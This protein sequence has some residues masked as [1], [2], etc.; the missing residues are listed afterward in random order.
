M[1]A[2][3][4]TAKELTEKQYLM[5]YKLELYILGYTKA[6][7]FTKI[8]NLINFKETTKTNYQE[9]TEIH[10]QNYIEYLHKKQLHSNTIQHYYHSIQQFFV[11]LER[12]QYL[13]KNPCNFYR[14]QLVKQPKT[15]REILSQEEVKEVYK[16]ARKGAETMLLHLCYGCGLRAK[17][18]ERIN[19]EDILLS[20]HIIKVEKGKN[21]QYRVLPIPISM[22]EDIT[23]YLKYNTNKTTLQKALLLN[24]QGNRLKAY[25][26]RKILKSILQRTSITKK[27]TLHSLRHSI[28]T[29]LLANGMK[30]EYVQQFLGHRQLETTEIYTHINKEQ[31]KDLR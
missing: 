15:I 2:F 3:G 27:I 8:R 10:L 18:L 12:E 21:N 14:L 30:S 1:I 20:Q 26:A 11:Y 24:K 25:T 6:T 19:V 28:A 29:H 31:L 16:A 7:I 5:S 22:L 23:N 17:E 9:T 4:K 13:I